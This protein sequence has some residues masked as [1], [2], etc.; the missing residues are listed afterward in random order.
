MHFRPSVLTLLAW[1]ILSG[2]SACSNPAP[3]EGERPAQ[4]AGAA[5]A[6][7][8]LA[9][10]A[11]V[12]ESLAKDNSQSASQRLI[13]EVPVPMRATTT[14]EGGGTVHLT[15]TQ[16]VDQ[17]RRFYVARGFKPVDHPEGFAIFVAE[18]GPIV[19]V[20]RGVGPRSEIVIIEKLV[21]AE[22]PP[23]PEPSPRPTEA[24][25]KELERRLRANE[26]TE[27]LPQPPAWER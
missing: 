11:A 1:L 15:V 5:G 19:Q 6:A 9:P 20:L 27:N 13:G 4:E 22:P 16:G 18:Q 21:Q 26:P 7:V 10:L 2:A 8:A 23:A 24:A 3:A 14:M 17:L 25:L 12:E